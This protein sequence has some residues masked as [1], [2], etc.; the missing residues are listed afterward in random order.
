MV[1]LALTFQ[2]VEVVKSPRDRN[3]NHEIEPKEIANLKTKHDEAPWVPGRLEAC[4][5]VLRRILGLLGFA[6]G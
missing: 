5:T 3:R 6:A 1:T 2:S 4:P